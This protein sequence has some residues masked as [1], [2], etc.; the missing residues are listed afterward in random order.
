M[1]V[2]YIASEVSPYA[3][4]GSLGETA[5]ELTA[6]LAR[7]GTDILVAMPLYGCVR[8]A[9]SVTVHMAG[10]DVVGDIETAGPPARAPMLFVRN[11]GYYR[12][13]AL[14][15]H[16]DEAER[17]VFFCRAALAGARALGF[18]PDVVHCNDWQTGIVPALLRYGQDDDGFYSETATVFTIHNLA[19]QGCFGSWILPMAGLPVSLLDYRSL[20]F[21]GQ[22]SLLK[23]G[24]VLADL[25]TTLSPTYAKEIQTEEHGEN[26]HGALAARADRLHGVLSG[27][28]PAKYD[29]AGDGTI[30]RR[31]SAERL[32]D[33]EE[34]TRALR[35]ECGFDP[36]GSEPMVAM[37][38][39]L[40]TQ[41]GLG[42]ITAV[43]EDLLDLGAL[44]V[45]L[46]RGDGYYERLLAHLEADHPGR[47]R[48]FLKH[49]PELARRIYAS[50]HFFLRPSVYEPCGIAQLIA[51][52]YGCVPIVR[53]TGGLADT[54][55]DADASPHGTGFTFGPPTCDALV[56]AVRR[57]IAAYRDRD[58]YRAIQRRAMASDFTWARSAEEYVRLYERALSLTR[59]G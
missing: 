45:V 40:T 42:I 10:R 37:V 3:S 43:A 47:M 48:V 54:V 5:G 38:T 19:H 51:L 36:D 25:V 31:F 32:D 8:T 18:R 23:A 35:A 30:V 29:P 11:D 58:R 26:L 28:D 21:Y 57:A 49:D 2:L 50:S 1:R 55:I 52:R 46:G 24:L 44:L 16:E 15:G 41:R 39:R 17:F 20:E 59:N 53:L 4:T 13:D 27:V 6:A 22:V 7:R 56:D 12:R 34:N 33:R 14:Y 9:A